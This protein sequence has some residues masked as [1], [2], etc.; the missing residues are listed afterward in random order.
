MGWAA[1]DLRPLKQECCELIDD[2]EQNL[3]IVVDHDRMAKLEQMTCGFPVDHYKL[4]TLLKSQLL[5]GNKSRAKRLIQECI[6][7][8]RLS[9]W[10]QVV[11]WPFVA[12]A[13]VIGGIVNLLR[14]VGRLGKL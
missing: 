11:L 9:W 10:V 3:G 4:I 14:P 12:V 7:D 2:M 6:P 13:R 5:S 8:V 1:T